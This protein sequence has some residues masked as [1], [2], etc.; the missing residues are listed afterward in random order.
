MSIAPSKQNTIKKLN[1]FAAGQVSMPPGA[2]Q[3]LETIRGT[4][5]A[6]YRWQNVTEAQETGEGE[7]GVRKTT[8]KS[9]NVIAL[10]RNVHRNPKRWRRD[11]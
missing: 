4:C 11:R 5:R 1:G 9:V 10:Q 8:N 3:K 2:M 7:N 6:P